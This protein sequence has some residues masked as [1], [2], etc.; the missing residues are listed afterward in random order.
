[1]K[2]SPVHAFACRLEW[3][4]ARRGSLQDYESYSR[5]WAVE[6][7]GKPTLRGSAAAVFRGDAALHN[8]EDLLVAALSSCHFL[9]YAALCARH[10]IEVLAYEDTASGTMAYDEPAK[11]MRFTEV[12]LRPKVTLARDADVDKALS[13]HARAHHE[14]FIANSV[15]F[16]VRNI[17]EV[18]VRRS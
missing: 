12:V 7:A 11:V 17:P 16:P 13:L 14:C 8:P 3:T 2:S 9:S 15:S 4:G 1:M 5:E 6:I 18:F 10:R